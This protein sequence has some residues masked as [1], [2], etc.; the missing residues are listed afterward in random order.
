M[1]LYSSGHTAST[2]TA[3]K[4]PPQASRKPPK[5]P[6]KPGAFTLHDQ[7]WEDP[8]SRMSNLND[9]VAMHHMDVYMVQE[10]K[11]TEVVLSDTDRFQ[12]KLQSEM[13]S[14]MSSQ[15]STPPF[16]WAPGIFKFHLSVEFRL[17][18]RRVEEG[19][20]YPVLCR[21]LATLKDELISH[22]SPTAGFD[23]ISGKG[24]EQKLMDYSQEAERFRGYAYEEVLEI[25][26]DH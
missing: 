15:L 26:P 4:P 1:Y 24:I 11:Y 25:S 12:S 22:K 23:F 6:Q 16:H 17:Y 2:S 19:K 5:P 9:K 20:Q 8:Y 14:R 18:Y 13:A 7:R 21:R 3:K 10:D